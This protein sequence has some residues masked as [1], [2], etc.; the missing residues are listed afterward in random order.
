MIHQQLTLT[1]PLFVV[2]TETTG[3]DTSTSRV[4]EIG[5]QQFGPEGLAREWRTLINPGIAIPEGAFKV[6][7]ISTKMIEA[8]QT[9]GGAK[10]ELLHAEDGLVCT[11]EQFRVAPRFAQISPNLAKGFSQC[12]FAG[13]NVRFDLR[14]LSAEFARA[15]TPWSYAGARIIDAE[16]LEQLGEPRDLSS[17]Y[18]RRCGKKL[19]GAHGALADVKASSELIQA[20]LDLFSWLPRD[21]DK[22]HEAQW[23][24]FLDSE[25]RFRIINDYAVCTFGKHKGTRMRDIPMDYYNWILKNDFPDEIKTLVG[26]AKLGKFPGA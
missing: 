20:Q 12:D 21:L 15:K 3:V 7:G 11:C 9:C 19:V 25:G 18:E 13:K 10:P 5:F 17:L 23:P 14:I 4:I 24:G 6:H 2:D 16:R 1:R 22:L 26:Q 8:C